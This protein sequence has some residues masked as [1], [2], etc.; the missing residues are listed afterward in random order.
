MR[1]CF[2]SR[3]QRR[4]PVRTVRVFAI[5]IS[6]LVTGGLT[7]C[8]T[9]SPATFHPG[10]SAGSANADPATSAPAGSG[11][12]AAGLIKLPF[13]SNVRI[14][15]PAFTPGSPDIAPVRTAQDFLLAFLY[16][17]YRGGADH[18][19]E[20]YTAGVAHRGLLASMSQP[21]VTTESF[22][23]TITFSHV[24]VFPDPSRHGAVDVSECFDNSHSKNTRLKSG[25]VLADHT[26]RN[27]HFYRNT[28]VLVRNSSGRWHVVEVY[29]VVYYPRAK[30]CKP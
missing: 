3:P 15:M 10:A 13:G 7:A 8:G 26:P 4:G 20:A 29:P 27:Q 21:D 6:A 5:A 30:E 16:S 25:R 9:S 2:G 24:R 12:S 1:P 23:G 11:A 18:R 17:E 28:D 22:K 14:V 19:W